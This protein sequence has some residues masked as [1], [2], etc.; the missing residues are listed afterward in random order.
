MKTI[1]P[2]LFLITFSLVTQAQINTELALNPDWSIHANAVLTGFR[3][4]KGGVGFAKVVSDKSICQI[5]VAYNPTIYYGNRKYYSDGINLNTGILFFMDNM[6]SYRGWYVGAN[7]FT[8]YNNVNIR[9]YMFFPSYQDKFRYYRKYGV[10]N[11]RTLDYGLT[12]KSGIR[13]LKNNKNFYVQPAML[14]N[15]FSRRLLYAGPVSIRFN[16]D[17]SRF[18]DYNFGLEINVGLIKYKKVK[19]LSEKNIGEQI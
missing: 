9:R 5:S 14:F 8:E 1:A 17:F 13:L 3:D 18:L 10:L 4:I 7:I 16:S 2:L 6:R 12:F 15:L 19:P 11:I